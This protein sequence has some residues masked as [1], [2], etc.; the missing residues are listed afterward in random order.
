MAMENEKHLDDRAD[1]LAR[2]F[3]YPAVGELFSDSDPRR[4]DDFCA[5]LEQRRA[6]LERLIRRGTRDESDRATRAVK[7]ID[8]TLEFIRDLQNR[9]RAG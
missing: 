1:E 4:V 6:D 8:V 7:G 2:L 9:R 5:G 3:D